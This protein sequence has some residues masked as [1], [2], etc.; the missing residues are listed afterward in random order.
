MPPPRTV[1]DRSAYPWKNQSRS[2]PDGRNACNSSLL[3][4]S[5]ARRYSSRASCALCTTTVLRSPVPA[6]TSQGLLHL[7][8]TGSP[9]SHAA[10][11]ACAGLSGISVTGCGMS[12]SAHT[13]AS[14]ALSA[15]RSGSAPG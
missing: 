12:A 9:S 14:S 4:A 10:L 5:S 1:P 7:A 3:P 13:A 15:T 2:C 6:G 11:A 8:T